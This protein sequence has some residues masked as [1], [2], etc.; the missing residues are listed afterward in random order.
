MDVKQIP[1]F[2]LLLLFLL[3][4]VWSSIQPCYLEHE[5]QDKAE[6]KLRSHYLQP[7]EPAHVSSA[8][9][10]VSCPVERYQDLVPQSDRSLSP[11]RFVYDVNLA[12]FPSRLAV[13]QCLCSGCILVSVTNGVQEE[14][15]NYNSALVL[16]S[17]LLLRKELCEDGRRYRLVPDKVTVPVGCTCVRPKVHSS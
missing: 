7:P 1:A 4:P 13:A 10:P 12:R 3:V 2:L 14:S 8:D 6:R 17:R 16:Q 15:M 5:L 9:S 11:W